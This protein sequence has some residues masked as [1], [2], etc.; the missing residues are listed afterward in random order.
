MEKIKVAVLGATGIVGQVFM[1]MLS[2][3]RQFE[4]AF[5]TAS[6]PRIGKSYGDDARW[7][8]PFEMP[9]NIKHIKF[10]EL[11]YSKLEKLGIKVVFSA[12]L[13]EVA[14]RVEPELRANNFWVFSNASALR[15]DENVPI[16]IPEVN[17]ESMDLIMGQGFPEKG[18]VITNANCSVTGLAVALAPLR[19]FGIKEVFVSTYQAISGAGYPG[20]S[21]LDISGNLIPYIKEE[22]EKID[23]ELKK[24]LGIEADV[25]PYCVRT[26]NL[27]GHL[28]TVWVKFRES[29][30]EDAV[31]GA[32][33]N[34][35]MEELDIPSLPQKPIVY[36][37]RV[38]FPQPKMSFFGN[39]PGMPVFTGRVRKEK[40][41]IGFV[42]L[43]N[44]LVKGA[45]GGSIQNA[46][47]FIKRFGG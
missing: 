16:L 26:P 27:F 41:R 4:I 35:K 18:F 25:F 22:E 37:K 17:I 24:I 29:V 34:F 32:W 7:M 43:V 39:P 30:N 36:D 46:E 19:K 10:E 11:D 5:I 1:W 20:L 47:A 44:N 31:I 14:M 40:D 28:E 12:L 6:S 23:I 33:E 38:D 3:H 8:L 9:D 15:Y 45:A 13:S 42:L 21:A 2:N